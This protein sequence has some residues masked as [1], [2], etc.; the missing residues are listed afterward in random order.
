MN[1]IEKNL[2]LRAQLDSVSPRDRIL[3]QPNYLYVSK[4]QALN[5]IQQYEESGYSEVKHPDRVMIAYESIQPYWEKVKSFCQKHRVY[6]VKEKSILKDFIKKEFIGMEI[7]VI[8]GVNHQIHHM[9]GCGAIPIQISTTSMVHGFGSGMVEIVIPEFIYI[10]IHGSLPTG[11]DVSTICDYLLDYF[12][13]SLVGFGVILGGSTIEQ[14]KESDR[15][16]FTRFITDSGAS[17]GVISPLGSF[18]QVESV[19]KIDIYAIFSSSGTS[20]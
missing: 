3:I 16:E 14:L 10:D 13:D 1:I 20:V 18:G 4:I 12:N 17:L 15:R 19:I 5:V 11:M 2:A 6:L 9:G 8:C 7:P